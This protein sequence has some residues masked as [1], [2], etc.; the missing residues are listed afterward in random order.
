MYFLNRPLTSAMMACTFLAASAS[1]QAQQTGS[2]GAQMGDTRSGTSSEAPYG[3]SS[4]S[5]SSGTSGAASTDAYGNPSTAS[6]AGGSAAGSST[7]TPMA[8]DPP[9]AGMSDRNAYSW[10]PYTTHGYVGVNAGQAKLDNLPCAPAYSCDDT[11]DRAY[12][13]YTGGMFNDHFG[14][15]LGYFNTG[16][17][18]RSGGRVRAHGANLSLVAQAPLGDM[19][20]V[21]AK[22]GAT[23]AWT[24]TS[25][26]PL[27]V[28][29][30]SGEK[31]GAGAAYGVGVRLN[32]TRNW[33]FVLEW[34][35]H[36]L[37]FAGDDKQATKM[38]TLGVQYRF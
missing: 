16:N 26:G 27:A 37:K 38:T 33:A 20:A 12:K 32:A 21:Y 18:D 36:D 24:K 19:A 15:E 17:I 29:T 8:F 6:P 13:V 11:S 30:P 35:Q 28:G 31:S 25:V 23:Y 10:L 2:S 34:D 22:V 7:S 3:A 9:A 5:P 14:M 1:V 4:T